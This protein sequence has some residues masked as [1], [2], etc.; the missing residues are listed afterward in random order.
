MLRL[1]ELQQ[2]DLQKIKKGIIEIEENPNPFDIR[3]SKVLIDYV[4]KNFEGLLEHLTERK[5]EEQPAGWV[6][7]T[8]LFLFD[9]DAF[10]GFYN[11]RHRLTE[12]LLERGGHIAYEVIPS[13]RGKGYVKRGLKMAL[14]WCLDTFGLERVMISCDAENIPSDR[15][16]TSVMNEVGG[17]RRE[18]IVIDGH[19]ER[20][21]WI[22]T[23]I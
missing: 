4:K 12:K 14:K 19:V 5:K 20:R 15:A 1:I 6:P 13:Q 18:D 7:D 22:N 17:E 8:T 23:K 3:Q 11:I 21:V 9:D 10:I 2:E 16:M